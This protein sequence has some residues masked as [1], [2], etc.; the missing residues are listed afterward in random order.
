VESLLAFGRN[1][2]S[3]VGC[4]AAEMQDPQSQLPECAVDQ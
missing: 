4:E 3:F 2:A 1:R